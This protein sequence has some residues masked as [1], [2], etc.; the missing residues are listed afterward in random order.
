MRLDWV[1]IAWWSLA[2]LF[3]AFCWFLLVRGVTAVF[4]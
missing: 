3:S 1:R 2:L 4:R